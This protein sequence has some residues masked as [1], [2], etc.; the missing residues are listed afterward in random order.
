ML[1][2]RDP[3]YSSFKVNNP[4]CCDAWINSRSDRYHLEPRLLPSLIKTCLQFH[5]ALCLFRERSQMT[6]KCCENKTVA[7]EPLGVCV[8]YVL[9]TF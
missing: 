6:S 5:V 1:T 7:H 3:T 2:R 8:T 4:Y 9:P